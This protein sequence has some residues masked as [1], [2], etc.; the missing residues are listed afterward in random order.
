MPRVKDNRLFFSKGRG[1]FKGWSMLKMKIRGL[2]VKLQQE[3]KP[4]RRI[5]VEAKKGWKRKT[6]ILVKTRSILR[7]YLWWR[8]SKKVVVGWKMPFGLM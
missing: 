6:T 4:V 5:G 1:L 3:E 8:V 2:G 7:A